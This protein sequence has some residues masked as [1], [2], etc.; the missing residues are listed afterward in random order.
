MRI[1]FV[2]VLLI[3]VVLAGLV[4]GAVALTKAAKPAT[5]KRV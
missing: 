5:G 3:A 2:E 1:H 4:A